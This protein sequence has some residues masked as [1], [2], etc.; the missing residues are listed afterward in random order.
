M[1]ED[2]VLTAGMQ[3]DGLAQVLAGH[4]AALNVPAGAA[5]APGAFPV[6]L[7]GLGG[8]PDG[9]IRGIFLQIVIHLAAQG[10]VAALQVIQIQV[11]QLA[12]AGVRL[13]AEVHVAVA[14]HVS[15][16]GV[17]Q[18]L[19]DVDD[20]TDMLGSAGAHGRRLDIQTVRVL[21]VL[22][23]KLAGH[24][25]HAGALFLAFFNQLIVN[26]GDVG[27]IVHLIAAVFQI[28]A[29][30]VKHDHRAGIADVDVV[31]NRRAADVDTV[32]TGSLRNKFLFLAGHGV[33]DLHDTL[34]SLKRVSLVSI[35]AAAAGGC[36]T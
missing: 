10:A 29:Q 18:V 35:I 27:N 12:I 28:A 19:D 32:F 11:A 7:A 13:H 21:D 6:G 15:M 22:G 26:I 23:L 2:Q 34:S 9:E 17:D 3:V 31:I 20:L 8:L 5:V 14:G 1:G 24:L 25:L 36:K 30:G 16:A 4:G 33:K